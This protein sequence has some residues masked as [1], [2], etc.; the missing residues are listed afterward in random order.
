MVSEINGN[1][2]TW[3]TQGY[4]YYPNF[5]IKDG[6]VLLNNVFGSIGTVKP[7]HNRS[8]T[9]THEV[10]HYFGLLHTFEGY[11]SCDMAALE[12]TCDVQGDKVCD[13]PP[14]VTNYACIPSCEETNS[15]YQ[16]YMDY[17][18]QLCRNMFTQGQKNRMRGS[19]GLF[20]T[21]RITLL[22]SQ[23]CVPVDEVNL[24]ITDSRYYVNCGTPTIIPEIKIQNTGGIDV[25]EF[26]VQCSVEGT[27]YSVI[28]TWTSQTPLTP[29]QDIVI[30]CWSGPHRTEI[31]HPNE[32]TWLPM[33]VGTRIWHRRIPQDLTE[34]GMYTPLPNREEYLD[35]CKQWC[36]YGTD[37]ETGRLNKIKNIIALNSMAEYLGIKVINVNSFGSFPIAQYHWPVGD[38]EFCNW[39][40]E[41]QFP[42]TELGHFYHPAHVAF[43]DYVL[44]GLV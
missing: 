26:Q 5:N 40:L 16:N 33:T 9:F 35:Y 20:S 38:T 2:G 12:S 18:N 10:G 11:N 23:G 42:H 17:T 36:T 14:T 19:N 22:D 4:A 6:I 31:W 30:A 7:T 39:C 41:Q 1:N 15:Q 43:A 3:G 25:Y 24:A 8:R 44:K 34:K 29:N 32:K 37:Q 13:T 21:P 27:G 28:E